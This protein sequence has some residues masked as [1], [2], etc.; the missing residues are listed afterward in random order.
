[1][2]DRRTGHVV[3]PSPRY[4]VIVPGANWRPHHNW[5]CSA[6][7]NC[8][9]NTLSDTQKY[10]QIISNWNN[11]ICP[12]SSST[13][14]ASTCKFYFSKISFFLSFKSH[15][16]LALSVLDSIQ[17]VQQAIF[18]PYEYCE[19]LIGGYSIGIGVEQLKCIVLSQSKPLTMDHATVRQVNFY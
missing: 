11:I 15:Y 4:F 2:V 16:H 19:Q 3:V 7:S 1:M 8:V 14:S 18:P 9:I 10:T 5:T 13:L 6:V 17:F 12:L